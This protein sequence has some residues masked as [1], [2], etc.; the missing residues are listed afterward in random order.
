MAGNKKFNGSVNVGT[1]LEASELI[2]TPKIYG[3]S[4]D[5]VTMPVKQ[6]VLEGGANVASNLVITGASD[7]MISLTSSDSGVAIDMRDS[8]S[9][10]FQGI[11][12]YGSGSGALYDRLEL[13]TANTV[14]LTVD[15]YGLRNYRV[16]VDPILGD[17]TLDA[18]DSGKLIVWPDAAAT[19]TLPDSGGGDILGTHFKFYSNFQGT[20]QKVVCADTTNEKLIGNLM[21]ARTDDDGADAVAWNAAAG[22]DFSSVNFNSAAQGEPGSWFEVI[23]VAADVWHIN[24]IVNQ[25]GG[26]EATPF[27]TT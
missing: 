1:F 20:G 18:T 27:A 21:T 11:T 8:D 24:G 17:S 16:S 25:S 4:D 2:K 3:D 9:N 13:K 22:D 5:V 10:A 15:G 19:F 7:P 12:C 23:N 26:S 6:L 14:R